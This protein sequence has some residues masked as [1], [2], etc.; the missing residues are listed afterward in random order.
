MLLWTL[1]CMYLFKLAFSFSSSIC[2]DVGLL[3][4]R[5]V[6]F[7]VFLRKLY[8]VFHNGCTN[9]H[10]HQQCRRVPFSPHLCH[11]LLFVVFL[12]IAIMA[13]VRWY[14]IVVLISTSVM[15]NDVEHLFMCLLA[16]CMSSLENVSSSLL[17]IF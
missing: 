7:L 16:I 5:V 15:S 12:M 14:L 1:G 8:T 13:G 10:S 3:D 11:H 2:P 17:S 9:L 6:L 4:H